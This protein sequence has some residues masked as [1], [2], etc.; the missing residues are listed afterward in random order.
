ML[1]VLFAFWLLVPVGLIVYHLGPGRNQ[2]AVD[3]AGFYLRSAEKAAARNNWEQAAVAY[4]DAQQAFPASATTQRRRIALAE[5]TAWIRAGQL[6]RGYQLLE[7]LVEKMAAD[8]SADLSL[9][10]AARHKLGSA[11]YCAAWLLRVQKAPEEVWRRFA[12]SAQ[13]QFR[14]LAAGTDSAAGAVENGG[15]QPKRNERAYKWNLEAALSLEQ[16][17]QQRIEELELPAN[18]PECDLVTQIANAAD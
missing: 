18:C 13:D 17:D 5:A 3:R 14:L 2:L 8:A 7:D 4:A 6:L 1:R 9:L 11:A 12:K 16:T 15:A 10:R